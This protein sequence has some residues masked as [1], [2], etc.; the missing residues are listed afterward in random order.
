MRAHEI[1]TE[2]SVYDSMF[3]KML[4]ALP[5]RLQSLYR[6]EINANLREWK[7]ILKKNDRIVWY[8]KLLKFELL[9]ELLEKHDHIP[10]KELQEYNIDVIRSE[11]QKLSKQ[12][13]RHNANVVTIN[14]YL[15]HYLSLPVPKIQ[16][17]VWG[18]ESANQLIDI[19][20]KYE[21]EW[22]DKQKRGI[23]IQEGDTELIKM[24]KYSWWLLNRGSCTEEGK[25]MGHCGNTA[26]GR[27]DDRIL[28]LRKKTSNG[29]EPHLT[30]ILHKDGYL[31]EMKGR[32]NEKPIP[33]YHPYIVKLLQH[34]IVS[35]IIG[36]G[37]KPENNFSINDLP[38]ETA[39][40]LIHKKVGLGSIK[41]MYNE[42]G[43][44]NQL[45]KK[46]E[47]TLVQYELSYEGYD[48]YTDNYILH[49]YDSIKEFAYDV[50]GNFQDLIKYGTGDDIIDINYSTNDISEFELNKFLQYL[51]EKIQDE[52]RDRV[53]KE[54]G[55]GNYKLSLLELLQKTD[56]Q[57][58]ILN[59]K[60]A[61]LE[62]MRTGIENDILGEIKEKCEALTDFGLKLEP[63]KYDDSIFYGRVQLCISLPNLIDVMSTEGMLEDLAYRG[64]LIDKINITE[65]RNGWN[66]YDDD[67]AVETFR[68]DL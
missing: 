3:T 5:P 12:F 52:V 48:H 33:E 17:H 32:G 46:I 44:S 23:R 55:Y 20:D 30:F 27:S 50:T 63:F 64:W 54:T 14:G 65:P 34:D 29:W 35:G 53:H 42:S 37:Y 21:Q 8:M 9:T 59:A 38:N 1:I 11:Q 61:I 57:D 24:G 26:A 66:G 7:A 13:N 49:T 16:N 58:L 45:L 18:R 31:G 67:A 10:E 51:P 36:G 4:S 62:G 15:K 41:E 47:L 25:A 60:N 40:Q 39:Y 56:S 68:N 43:V 28:S 2:S 19:F 6:N 22:I